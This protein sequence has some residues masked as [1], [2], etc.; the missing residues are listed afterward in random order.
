[1]R[2]FS[3][4]HYFKQEK[5]GSFKIDGDGCVFTFASKKA[6]TFT[7]SKDSH[8]PIALATKRNEI[9]KITFAGMAYLTAA[10]SGRLNVSKAQEELLLWHGILGYYDIA[11]T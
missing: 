8:L 2:L 4:Q 9:S 11:D 6:L 5:G 7:Y 1:M 3:P 10:N